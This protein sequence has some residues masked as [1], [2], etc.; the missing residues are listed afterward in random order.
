MS[1]KEEEKAVKIGLLEESEGEGLGTELE[2]SVLGLDSERG[3]DES[4]VREDSSEE[5]GKGEEQ[6]EG[7]N[8]KGK[9]KKEGDDGEFPWGPLLITYL[10]M[11][12][13]AITMTIIQPLAPDQ[14]REIFGME[15]ASGTCTGS[16]VGAFTFG[17]CVSGLLLGHFADLWGRKKMMGLGLMTG[18][19]CTWAYG[20]CTNF[21]LGV[22]IRF[23]AGATNANL[24]LTRAVVAD[25]TKGKHRIVAFGYLWSVFSIARTISGSLGGILSV[26]SIQPFTLDGNRFFFPCLIGGS[27]NLLTLFL[28]WFC[29]PETNKFIQVE[30]TEDQDEESLAPSSSS[31]SPSHSPLQKF[32]D[33]VKLIREDPLQLLLLVVYS[34]TSFS[35]GAIFAIFLFSLTEPAE[36]GGLGLSTLGAGLMISWSAFVGITYQ[37]TSFKKVSSILSNYDMF[38][39]ALF[40]FLICCIA[41]PFSTLPNYINPPSIILGSILAAFFSI[42]QS[43]GMMNALSVVTSMQSNITPP[44]IQGL[45]LG[46]SQTLSSLCRAFAPLLVGMLFDALS[47][48]RL[49][50]YAMWGVGVCYF[51]CYL[52]IR[53][54][55]E[56]DKWRAQ[57][58]R[59]TE[60]EEEA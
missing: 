50:T 52:L 10:I 45:A 36:D 54:M 49:G 59:F 51:V 8:E 20:V 24:V 22:F 48:I 53:R 33:G 60:E 19:L 18:W 23:L 55:T 6:E 16:L 3:S 37:F 9:G 14:C 41:Y 34:L 30:D 26:E 2:M 57:E 5:E 56:E 39:L 31:S 13:D 58:S 47:T 25:L 29:M 35:N 28:C 17:C 43:L 12:S 32:F 27:F 40:S 15:N 42:F 4:L 21:W 1:K 38:R 44:Q 7:K 46:A 11:A